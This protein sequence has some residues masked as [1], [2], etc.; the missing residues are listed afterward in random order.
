[1]ASEEIMLHDS[2][3]NHSSCRCCSDCLGMSEC[4]VHPGGG[5]VYGP[6]Y[7]P[8]CPMHR[9]SDLMAEI[10]AVRKLVLDLWKESK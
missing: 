8:E 5:D 2:T 9:G 6:G 4:A 10:A 1:M 3:F 7:N